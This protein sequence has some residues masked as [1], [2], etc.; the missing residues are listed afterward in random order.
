MTEKLTKKGKA[1]PHTRAADV[2]KDMPSH[3]K[4]EILSA[5][6]SLFTSLIAHRDATHELEG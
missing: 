2:P 5:V 1:L 3:E 4:H 6:F